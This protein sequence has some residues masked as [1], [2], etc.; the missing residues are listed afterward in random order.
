MVPQDPLGKHGPRLDAFLRFERG[1]SPNRE[2]N[3]DQNSIPRDKTPCPYKEKCTF[4]P[5][6]R[7]YHP[8]REIKQR[9]KESTQQEDNGSSPRPDSWSRDKE[10]EQLSMRMNQLN[11]QSSPQ[12]SIH[13]QPLSYIESSHDR[14]GG[15]RNT[16]PLVVPPSSMIPP[17]DRESIHSSYSHLPHDQWIRDDHRSTTPRGLQ[18]LDMGGYPKYPDPPSYNPSSIQHSYSNPHSHPHSNQRPHTHPHLISPHMHP[19]YHH[20]QYSLPHALH[21]NDR[22]GYSAKIPSSRSH[23]A[24]IVGGYSAGYSSYKDPREL[25]QIQ[26]LSNNQKMIYE[27]TVE[28]FPQH[29]DRI[30]A[31][32]IQYRISDINLL[33]QLLGK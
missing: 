26:S 16:H 28:M 14:Q 24:N 8:E 21:G 7:Y 12:K 17:K 19:D 10:E 22:Q 15:F 30:L 27:K 23:S 31:I 20:A 13:S 1:V 32:I 11:F 33:I 25:E 2:S 9:E 3:S 5:R 6:C 18:Q 29:K 4:G